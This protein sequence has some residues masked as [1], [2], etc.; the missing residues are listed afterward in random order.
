M[1]GF[2]YEYRQ[3]SKRIYNSLSSK[4]Q[5]RR[6]FLPLGTYPCRALNK[7][8]SIYYHINTPDVNIFIILFHILQNP[9][10]IFVFQLV[11]R[12]R[13]LIYNC[14]ACFETL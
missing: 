3:L 12:K 6:V 7:P 5:F 13:K 8:C 9:L 2:S 10:R 4:R 11:V 14:R 1:S